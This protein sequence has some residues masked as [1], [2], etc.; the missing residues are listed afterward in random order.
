MGGVVKETMVYLYNEMSFDQEN[1]TIPFVLI[2]KCLQGILLKKKKKQ[3]ARKH[4]EQNTMSRIHSVVLV[5]HVHKLCDTVPSTPLP[6][7]VG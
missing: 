4:I 3:I 5:K 6:W 2:W 1:D 7:S